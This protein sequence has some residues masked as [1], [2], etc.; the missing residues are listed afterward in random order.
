RSESAIVRI[1]YSH[2]LH[3]VEFCTVDSSGRGPVGD[4]QY[5]RPRLVQHTSTDRTQQATGQTTAT[6]S[7]HHDE[8]CAGG[9]VS[10][11]GR[12]RTFEQ[13]EASR[14]A[15]R[16][17][18]CHLVQMVCVCP[19][20]PGLLVRRGPARGSR[21]SGD[22]RDES[23]STAAEIGGTCGDLSDRQSRRVHIDSSDDLVLETGLILRRRSMS[24]KSDRSYLVEVRVREGDDEDRAM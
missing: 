6:S 2:V 22:G 20:F 14:A 15:V 12:C 17:R 1:H 24:F 21:I 23:E 7:P 18:L 8:C 5:G 19:I 11:R 4:D 16:D 3:Y 13:L 9:G 10:Q